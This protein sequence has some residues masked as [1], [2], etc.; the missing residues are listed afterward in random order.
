MKILRT[1]TAILIILV[2]ALA[3]SSCAQ[4]P[5]KSENITSPEPAPETTS[6]TIKS[7]DMEEEPG[8]ALENSVPGAPQQKQE[9]P[10]AQYEQQIKV[11]YEPKADTIAVMKDA[12]A[13]NKPILIDFWAVWCGPCKELKPIIEELQAQYSSDMIFLSIDVDD[14]EGSKLADEFKVEFIPDIVIMNANHEITAHYNDFVDKG[15]LEK[16]IKAAIGS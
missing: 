13:K 2:L 6:K 10:P 9:E 5:I 7:E 3:L 8:P 12:L 1:L 16:S 14:T 4:M 11:K 15:S